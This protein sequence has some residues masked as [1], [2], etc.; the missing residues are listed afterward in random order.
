MATDHFKAYA[1]LDGAID[2]N[3]NILF[4]GQP[5]VARMAE[6]YA[7]SIRHPGLYRPSLN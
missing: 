7:E 3:F 6:A 4:D 1:H 2:W 5:Q